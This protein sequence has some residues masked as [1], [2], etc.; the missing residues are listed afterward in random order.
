MLD[1]LAPAA[2]PWRTLRPAPW[3][4][5]VLLVRE[6]AALFLRSVSPEAI[7]PRGALKRHAVPEAPPSGAGLESALR[8]LRRLGDR[9]GWRAPARSVELAERIARLA[10][11]RA[12]RLQLRISPPGLGGLRLVLSIRRQLLHVTLQAERP[13]SAA[14]IL[15]RWPELRESLEGLGFEVG[16][17]SVGADGA[18]AQDGSRRE[19]GRRGEEADGEAAATEPASLRLQ[20]MDVRV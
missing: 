11:R 14:A 10:S 17:F 1:A 9:E 13:S 6:P 16:E 3:R 4:P 2:G 7:R 20:L 18:S 15:A 5:D 8:S 19:P 12:A